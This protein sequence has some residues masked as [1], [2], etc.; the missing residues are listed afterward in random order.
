MP[1]FTVREARIEAMTPAGPVIMTGNVS[2]NLPFEAEIHA[3][4]EPAKLKTDEGSLSIE[5]GRV[6]LELAG[7]KLTGSAELKLSEARF[8]TFEARNILLDA[9]MNLGFNHDFKQKH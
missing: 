3:A 1:K 9:Q 5:E 2:G 8:Q 4:I 6:D 7:V